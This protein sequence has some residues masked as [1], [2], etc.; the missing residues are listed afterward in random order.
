MT[1]RFGFLPPALFMIFLVACTGG[2]E[3]TAQQTDSS[4]SESQQVAP[5]VEPSEV[6]AQLSPSIPLYSGAHY[7]DDL[8]RRDSV[9][10]RNQF[11]PNAKIYT[12]ASDDS[13]P[14]VW[15]YYVTYLAQYRGYQPPS[16]YPPENQEWRTIQVNLSQAMQDPFIPDDNLPPGD[17]TVILQVAETESEPRTLIRYIVQPTPAS[18]VATTTGAAPSSPA[19]AD[20]APAAPGESAEQ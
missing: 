3:T 8:T 19:A 12:L 15:H 10:L 18:T 13:F 16:P 5:K 9:M 17:R 7:R 1:R 20:A 11:G 6:L 2:Q 4:T 14:Q